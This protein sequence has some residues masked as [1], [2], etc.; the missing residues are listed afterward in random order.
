MKGTLVIVGCFVAGVL[1]AL[2][3]KVPA[4]S[5]SPLFQSV[6][7][8]FL[9]L[10]VGVGIGSEPG[11]S[12]LFRGISISL[13]FLP[14]VVIVGS[15]LGGFV[16]SLFTSTITIKQGVAIASGMGYYSLS[17]ILLNKLCSEQIGAM[18]LIANLFREVTTIL[19]FPLIVRYFGKIGGV[20]SGG[21]TS[22]DTTLPLIIH[23]SGKEMAVV[24]VYS[25]LVITLLVPVI[26][27]V[28]MG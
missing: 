28:L 25:G 21:A 2:F 1:V 24:A 22:M 26:I 8:A 14:V 9:L 3:F 27:S 6:I 16:A 17:S 5:H 13:L 20:A 4:W 18:A 7:L 10:L 23:Y 15:L 11:V 12:H 19:F